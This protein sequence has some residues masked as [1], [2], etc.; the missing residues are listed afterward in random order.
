VNWVWIVVG[1]AG[2]LVVLSAVVGLVV[3]RILGNI[4][5]EMSKL[6]E[7]HDR[8]VVPARPASEQEGKP[9]RHFAAGGSR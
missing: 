9:S 4:R 6:D 3:A 2:L 7:M 8:A 1:L 5:L